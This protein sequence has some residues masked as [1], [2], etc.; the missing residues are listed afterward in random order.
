MELVGFTI[1]KGY[2]IILLDM[3]F[4]QYSFPSIINDMEDLGKNYI[5]EL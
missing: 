1:V 2:V 5:S 4:Y 3:E